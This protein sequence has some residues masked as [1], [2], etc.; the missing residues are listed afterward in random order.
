[1]AV[2]FNFFGANPLVTK[3]ICSNLVFCV[4]LGLLTLCFSVEEAPHSADLLNLL[5]LCVITVNRALKCFDFWHLGSSRALSLTLAFLALLKMTP[6]V[7]TWQVLIFLDKRDSHKWRS[8]SKLQNIWP[9]WTLL[10]Q[11]KKALLRTET[12]LL[13][14]IDRLDINQEYEVHRSLIFTWQNDH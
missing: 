13:V 4:N 10:E 12:F 11:V 1:M 6:G 3:E 9:L 2:E 7:K 5:I 8:V 14:E